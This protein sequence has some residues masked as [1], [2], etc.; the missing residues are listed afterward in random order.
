MTHQLSTFRK[1][2]VA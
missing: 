2:Y 1:R